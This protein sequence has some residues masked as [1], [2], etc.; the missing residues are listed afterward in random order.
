MFAELWS[1]MDALDG[2]QIVAILIGFFGIT[3]WIA[4]LFALMVEPKLPWE[5][6]L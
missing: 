3:V 4:N 6:D 1:A 2:W 5:E